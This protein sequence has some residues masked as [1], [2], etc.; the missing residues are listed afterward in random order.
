MSS[1]LFELSIIFALLVA[2]GIFSM[3]E[4]AI[5]SSR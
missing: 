1:I 5:V 4:I 3:A 2:N